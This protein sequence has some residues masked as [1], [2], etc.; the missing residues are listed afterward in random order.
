VLVTGRL[1]YAL[2]AFGEHLIGEEIDNGI[3]AAAAAIDRHVSDYTVMA[4]FPSAPDQRGGHLFMV[5]FSTRVD[6]ARLAAFAR[7]LD[8]TL[9][10][11]NQDYRDHRSAGFGMMPPCVAALAPGSFAGW[12]EAEGRL[13]GQNKVPRVLHD[14][15]V[16]HRLRDF[17]KRS[18]G[19]YGVTNT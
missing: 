1:S 6:E 17:F 11:E 10:S 14:P 16:I 13:G 2:S 18:G 12:L 15:G 7:R 8:E 9:C 3:E 4:T 19:V 5:E